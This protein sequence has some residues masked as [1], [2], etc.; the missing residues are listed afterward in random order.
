[1]LIF[2]V[3]MV[4]GLGWALCQ[5]WHWAP[6]FW[7]Q[8][9][10]N[11]WRCWESSG[12]IS[13]GIAYG[14]AYYLVNRPVSAEAEPTARFVRARPNLERFGAYLGLLLGLGL[15][16][17][18]GLKGWANIYLG[19][20]DYWSHILWLVAG[21]LM[22]AG[23]VAI[24]A[25]LRWRPLP[26]DFEGDV[27]P[28]AYRLIWLVLITQ[29]VIAQLITGPLTAWNEVAFS[30]YY[31]GL[32]LLTGVIVHHFQVIKKSTRHRVCDTK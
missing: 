15:S 6:G 17:R 21:P 14:I 25:W 19:H 4:N 10:F 9:N 8:A 7:P 11:W 23:L 24:I 13:I 20:E 2:T 1:M 18:N 32:F 22:L 27:F 31:V 5:N 30:L 12:G 28:H 3:G 16:L 26:R 29:N